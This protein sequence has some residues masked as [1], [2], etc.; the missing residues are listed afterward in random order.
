L[1]GE[2]LFPELV[3]P[4]NSEQLLADDASSPVR[5]TVLDGR[6]TLAVSN[7]LRQT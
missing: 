6:V 7:L 4:I 3:I 5:A 1:E 2:L